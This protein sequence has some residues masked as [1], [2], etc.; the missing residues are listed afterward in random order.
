M[1][2]YRYRASPQFWRNYRKLTE[3]EQNAAFRAWLIFKKDPFDARLGTHK[4]N[5]LSALYKRTVY[6]VEIERDFRAAFYIDG[7]TVFSVNIGS[8]GIYKT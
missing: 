2:R 7:D 6:A 8:H 3:R 4:I 5:S 1:K